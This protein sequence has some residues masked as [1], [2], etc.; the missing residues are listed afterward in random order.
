M[1]ELKHICKKF[2][3]HVILQDVN[4]VVHLGDVIA[5]IGPSGCGKSTLLNCIN[6]LEPASSGEILF[7]GVN[8]M[9]KSCNPRHYRQ[10]IGMV[11]Q[12]Y[13]LFG[14]M[15]VLENVM[16]PQVTL[17]HRSRQDACDVAMQQLSMVGM[18]DRILRYPDELSGGQ[19]QRV[20]IAR[21][22]AMDPELIL[23]DEPTSA[24]DPTMVGEV[25]YIIKKL[26]G[27]G[28][29]MLIVTHEMRFAR[30]VSNR[31][32]YMD[33]KGIYEDGPTEQIF[34]HPLREKTR[35]FVNRIKT[36]E[37]SIDSKYFDY[38]GAMREIEL[39]SDKLGFSKQNAKKLQLLFEEACMELL[40]PQLGEKP[41][42]RAVFEYEEKSSSLRLT[43]HHAGQPM[44]RS[45]ADSSSQRIIDSMRD[46]IT[47]EEAPE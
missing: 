47:V 37:L 21:T 16:Q 32:F 29:T 44:L 20:A 5:I 23:F 13:N 19:K 11:F 3:D 42:L 40:L 4:T 36:L 27:E 43:L 41:S 7:E 9:D 28:R 22:L 8:V 30:E 45:G 18:A 38:I 26:A 46:F 39:Y 1:I 25:E 17:L 33:E 34:D 24:L 31:V 14:H 15:T 6:L 10:K 12:S 2:G 35:R